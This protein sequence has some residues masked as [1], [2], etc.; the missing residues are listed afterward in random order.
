MILIT[1]GEQRILSKI[2]YPKQLN[3]HAQTN[4]DNINSV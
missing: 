3:W 4:I 1:V 2:T